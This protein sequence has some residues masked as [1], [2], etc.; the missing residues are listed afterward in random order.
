MKNIKKGDVVKITD[1]SR[2]DSFFN[3]FAEYKNYT[4]Q[5]VEICDSPD[6]GFTFCKVD[7]LPDRKRIICFYGVKLKKVNPIKIWIQ[8][9]AIKNLNWFHQKPVAP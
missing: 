7:L 4:Y 9:I 6:K 5:I 3:F 8:R 2:T 1:I